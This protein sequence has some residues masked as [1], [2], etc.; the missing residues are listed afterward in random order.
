M[1]TS[2]YRKKLH[3]DKKVWKIAGAGFAALLLAGI[4][5]FFT[6][7]RVENVEVMG[8]SHY[9]EE[10]VREMILRGPLASN[11]IL[12]PILYS[13]D[14]VGD[15]PFVEG[16]RVSRSNRNTIVITVREKQPVG[17]I[18][19]LDSYIYF[20]RNGIFIE[21]SRERDESVPYFDGIQ[22]D[23]VI[24]DE[25]LP[26]KGTTVLNTA[27][28]LATIFQKNE[29]IPDHI[30]F[31]SSYDI[32]LVYGDITVQLGKDEYLEDKMARVI[33]I[34]P[35]LA[36]QKGILHLET[37]TDTVKTITFEKEEVEYTA[38][39]WPGGYD[40]NGEYTGYD[41]YDAEGNYVGPKPMTELDYALEN[42]VGGYDEELV[43]TGTGEYDQ[44]GNYVGPAPTQE[45]IDAK[46]D[47][48]GG[49]NEEGGY[50]GVSEY[51]RE[52]NYVGPNPNA[53]EDGSE[54]DDTYSS[55]ESYEEDGYSEDGSYEDS[56][57]EDSYTD[58]NYYGDG[59]TDEGYYEDGY[60]DE[61]YY[62][63]G[64][65]DES[66]YSDSGYEEDYYGGSYEGY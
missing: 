28:A 57:T 54:T 51:D 23:H 8:S 64:Y 45:S 9:T 34:L 2:N 32:S 29:M 40:E 21:S 6:Y 12:A 26:I 49:Y 47:W 3:I 17:C 14:D 13:R 24:K 27:V 55:D 59:Y 15:I 66:S 19:Y 31:D 63:D 42:W 22:V 20:D 7:Y 44:Y 30:Q 60:T 5:F 41:E 50:D 58:E 38:E 61:S 33:A 4:V 56:Y 16:F 11:S 36:G 25:K 65:T 62:G 35:K 1:R 39:N 46:G 37:V 48:T 10:E 52:G 53:A 43:Y 18:P